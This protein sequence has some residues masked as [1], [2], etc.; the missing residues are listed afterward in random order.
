MIVMTCLTAH[1][2]PL[3]A[4]LPFLPLVVAALALFFGARQG[5]IW[6]AELTR[7]SARRSP[8]PLQHQSLL[9]ASFASLGAPVY[10][11]TVMEGNRRFAQTA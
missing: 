3:T 4:A 2:C 5:F 8:I 10:I 1:V 11:G 6:T 9:L 7:W